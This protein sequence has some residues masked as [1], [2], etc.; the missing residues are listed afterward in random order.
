MCLTL[1]LDFEV[2]RVRDSVLFIF[3]SPDARPEPHAYEFLKILWWIEFQNNVIE[4]WAPLT[5]CCTPGGWGGFQDG[6]GSLP[7][8]HLRDGARPPLASS[9]P[10][11]YS[12]LLKS[13]PTFLNEAFLPL[14]VALAAASWGWVAGVLRVIGVKSSVIDLDGTGLALHPGPLPMTFPGVWKF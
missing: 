7:S 8:R 10:T 12:L 2:L 11:L 3:M 9:V 5:M 1:P 14:C 4:Q 13:P 6:W